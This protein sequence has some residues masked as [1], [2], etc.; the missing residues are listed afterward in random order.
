MN[1]P[2]IKARLKLLYAAP[3]VIA[4][5]ALAVSVIAPQIARA[6]TPDLPPIS[7][8][9]LLSWIKSTSPIPLNGTVSGTTSFPVPSASL[10]NSSNP[11]SALSGSTTESY[12]VWTNGSGSFRA[13]QV[14]QASE[15]DL[16]VT[17]GSA[18][19]WNSA[20]LTA[21]NV[22]HSGIQA[23]GYSFRSNPGVTASEIVSRLSA[24]STLSVSGNTMVAGRPAYTLSIVP[25]AGDSLIGSIQIAVDGQTHIPVQVQIFPKG[26]TAP[27]ASLGYVTLRFASQPSSIFSFSPPSG[28]RVVNPVQNAAQ[29][30]KKPNSVGST[31]VV[32]TG[33]NSVVVATGV[34]KATSALGGIEKS[35]PVVA[36]SLG[37]GRL[38][39]TPIFEA[40]LL[41][42]GTVVAGAVDTSRLLQVVAGL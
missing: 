39:S 33:F 38:Y 37:S 25:T 24:Y 11:E 28:A 2:I 20:K 10:L 18:W 16:Y 8:N 7:P 34:S 30:G 36:T 15:T 12:N 13:Q 27:A 42:N 14:S 22:K 40:I 41:P 29:N 17:P 4:S 19:L 1:H 21:T 32:G 35:L 3:L 31:K 6:S 23:N 9:Q 26:S 5:T